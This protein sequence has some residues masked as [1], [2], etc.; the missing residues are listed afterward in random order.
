LSGDR[1]DG[2]RN[3]VRLRPSRAATRVKKGNHR[4]SRDHVTQAFEAGG[5]AG[6]GGDPVDSWWD[7]VW[8]PTCLRRH[9]PGN[10]PRRE[11]P[12]SATSY[13]EA[14]NPTAKPRGVCE[15]CGICL[16]KCPV[17]N[18][19]KEESRAEIVRLLNGEETERV[20]NECTFC[21]NCNRYCPLRGMG[22]KPSPLGEDFSRLAVS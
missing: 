8:H 10:H 7:A 17:M 9:G 11:L 16:Q 6:E 13:I 20:L 15:T 12:M 1:T 2:Q 4:T 5:A 19:S 3:P 14:F 21:F 22:E 18:M